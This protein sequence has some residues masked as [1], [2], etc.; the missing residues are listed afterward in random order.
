MRSKIRIALATA[1][2]LAAVAVA[3]ASADPPPWSAAFQHRR[4]YCVRAEP[5]PFRRRLVAYDP[6]VYERCEPILEKIHRARA[7]LARW[8]GTN[9]H[10]DAQRYWRNYLR[11]APRR[12]EQCRAAAL[13]G[14]TFAFD[15]DEE[16]FYDPEFPYGRPFDLRRDWPY[17]LGSLLGTYGSGLR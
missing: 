3:P 2:V 10:E 9:R 7:G 14:E 11:T 15:Q 4:A 6:I 1:A 16:F 5:R 8:G 13:R 12:L 17:L